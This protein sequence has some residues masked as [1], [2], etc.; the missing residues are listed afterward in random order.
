M[1]GRKIEWKEPRNRDDIRAGMRE[2]RAALPPWWRLLL[3]CVVAP[4]LL[5][6][7][8][9]VF[10]PDIASPATR[11]FLGNGL[12][13]WWSMVIAIISCLFMFWGMPYLIALCPK[14]VVLREKFISFMQGS[15]ALHIPMEQVLSVT[16]RGA[17]AERALVVVAKT[18]KG[19]EFTRTAKLSPEVAEAEIVGFL[20]EHG[21]AHLYRASEGQ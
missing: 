12:S 10:V 14:Y 9:A 15:G 20:C 7:L 13:Y 16:F 11:D 8:L 18:R 1:A 3:Y 5:F 17:G 4:V 2:C 19:R 21:L 6:G